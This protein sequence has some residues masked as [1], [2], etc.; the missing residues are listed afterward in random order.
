MSLFV[1]MAG[2]LSKEH[3]LFATALT[4]KTKGPIHYSYALSY[5]VDCFFSLNYP[6][7]LDKTRGRYGTSLGWTGVP[8]AAVGGGSLARGWV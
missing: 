1:S 4:E 6:T 5:K 3:T 2:D 7:S 8:E